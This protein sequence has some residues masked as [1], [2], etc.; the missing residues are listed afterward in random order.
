MAVVPIPL[1][2][3]QCLKSS[4]LTLGLTFVFGCCCTQAMKEAVS[5]IKLSSAAARDIFAVV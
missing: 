3:L 5:E 4:T 1:P 2:A